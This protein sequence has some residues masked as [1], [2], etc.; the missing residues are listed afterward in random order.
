METLTVETTYGQA[1]FDAAR[2]VGMID[3]IGEEFKAISKHFEENPL[4]RRLFLVPTLSATDKRTAAKNIFEGRISR[5][6]LNFIY[7]LIDKRR[8]N[9]WDGI[10]KHYEKLVWDRDGVTK[11]ILYTVLPVDTERRKTFEE[12][13]G[14]ALGKKIKLENRIDKSIIGGAVIYVDGKLIDASVKSRLE[15]MKQRI[16]HL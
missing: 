10:G 13:T 11:G 7:I 1:L 14:E 6:M 9:S 16:K 3:G 5:E 12:K 8:I 4:L 15:S 2:D